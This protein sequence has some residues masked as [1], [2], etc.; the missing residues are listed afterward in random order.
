MT[1][2]GSNANTPASAAPGSDY[3]RLSK[4]VKDAGLLN[5][6]AGYYAPKITLTLLAF[7][8][9]WVAFVAIGSSWWQLGMAAVMA[10]VYTQIAF[11]GHDAGHKQVFLTRLFIRSVPHAAHAAARH[12]PAHPLPLSGGRGHPAGSGPAPPATPSRF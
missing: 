10:V 12:R 7:V 9:G 6:R 4:L 8:G 1:T 2:I 5:R 3:A 11:I